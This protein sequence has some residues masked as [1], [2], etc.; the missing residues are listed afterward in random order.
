MKVLDMTSGRR[1]YEVRIEHSILFEC[2]L[3]IAVSTYT[4]IQGSLER[5]ADYWS[6]RRAA[7]PASLQAELELVERHNTWKAL[8]QLLHQKS[9]EDIQQFLFYIQELTASDLRYGCLPYLGMPWQEL[10]RLAAEGSV[11]AMQALLD[12]VAGHAFFPSLI[13]YVCQVDADELR[14]HLCDVTAG[15]YS[16]VTETEQEQI[17]GILARDAGEKIAMKDKL[18]P[19]ALVEWAT[20]G[21]AYAPEPAVTRVLLIPHVTYRPWNVHAEIEQTKIFY[22]PVADHNLEAEPDVYR[23][24]LSLVQ[25]YKAL[26]DEHRLRIVKLL[27]EKERTLQELTE[28]LDLAKSTIHHHLSLL[29]SAQ[30]VGVTDGVYEVKKAGLATMDA[31]LRHYLE[32]QAALRGG[33]DER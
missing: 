5:P 33:E 13:S 12:E 15:W 31:E 3:G 32:R 23:P 6:Q 26:G 21:L 8:L 28:H 18:H 30:L 9:F 14:R 4:A 11:D 24:A 10:R 16:A 1:S 17:R 7:L 22:Y 2:V 25:R 27:M 29:R 20:G 19:E